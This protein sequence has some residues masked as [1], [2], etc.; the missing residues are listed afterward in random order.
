MRISLI[1]ATIHRSKELHN[2]LQSLENQTFA[3]FEVII[4]DQN[5]DDKVKNVLSAFPNINIKRIKTAP[6]G[7]SNARNIGVTA[8]SGEIISFPDDDCA[9][10]KNTISN[11][12]SLIDSG[13]DLITGKCISGTGN[14]SV[15]NF[16]NHC[17]PINAYNVW[18]AG[19]EA[20]IFIKKTLFQKLHG[21]N[22]ELGLGSNTPY[23]AG[24]GTDLILRALKHTKN[25]R[26]FPDLEIYHPDVV[27]IY[28]EKAYRRTYTY[29]IGIG[30]V[31]K[32][33]NTPLISKLTMIIRPLGGMMLNAL[34]CNFKK[35][36]FYLLSLKGR[37]IGLF[38]KA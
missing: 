36:K 15:A 1:V 9:Y 10:F 2:F 17:V 7:V 34:K 35:S 8:A 37:L 11:A 27:S 38:S 21:F 5:S 12:L 26:Y 32:L 23:G 16:K 20:T 31:H 28:N 29:S 22:E 24:E 25:I 13:M 14:S 4:V 18:D 3:D 33:N 19:V 6:K 30:R